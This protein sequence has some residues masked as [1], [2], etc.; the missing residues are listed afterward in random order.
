LSTPPIAPRVKGGAGT[1]H[2]RDDWVRAGRAPPPVASEKIFFAFL[3]SKSATDSAT[4]SRRGAVGSPSGLN[5]SRPVNGR[6]GPSSSAE[7]I[8]VLSLLGKSCPKPSASSQAYRGGIWPLAPRE[9][10]L[11]GASAGK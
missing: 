11:I 7:R 10:T 5:A 4:G 1:F 8:G 6:S 2:F 9:G 3:P